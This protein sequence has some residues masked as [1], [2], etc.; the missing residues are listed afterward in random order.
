ME[1]NKEVTENSG[2]EDGA[3][4]TGEGAAAESTASDEQ[5]GTGAA[6]EAESKQPG[7]AGHDNVEPFIGPDGKKYWPEEAALGR[8][9]ALTA[10]LRETEGKASTPSE[11]LEAIKSNPELK[12]QWLEAIGAE[13]SEDADEAEPAQE[14]V[15]GK[16]YAQTEQ[17]LTSIQD[18]AAQ[19]FYKQMLSP[20]VND[21]ER[22]TA[23]YVQ[24]EIKKALAP[25]M[26]QL[27][28]SSLRAFTEKAK[29]FDKYRPKVLDIMKQT[30]API[31]LAYKAAKYDDLAKEL[32]ML[33]AGS[34]TVQNKQKL[35]QTPIAK[36]NTST[37]GSTRS[38][39]MDLDDAIGDSIQELGGPKN[40]RF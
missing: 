20:L 27:G 4:V 37:N 18:P 10:K 19:A 15:S 9:N 36:R 1:E 8:I 23:G 3:V 2:A 35:N 40:I 39:K 16:P 12:Q 38:D 25:V 17:W 28:E 30:Q 11:L 34:K 29:D 5:A 13:K 7:E 21:L 14:A 24:S 32:A 31:D 6:A 22:N 33:K 26:R